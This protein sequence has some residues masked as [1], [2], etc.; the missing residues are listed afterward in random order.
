MRAKIGRNDD[1]S[2]GSG[3]K[4][5]KCCGRAGAGA[6]AAGIREP[7]P[8]TVAEMLE[9]LRSGRHAE[10]ETQVR[11]ALETHPERG[12]L[13]KL[14]A[15]ALHAQHR[16]P[17]EALESAVRLLPKDP[18]A[19][20]N[21]GNALRARG[22]LDEA[23]EQHRRAIRLDASYAEAQVNLGSV[24]HEQGRLGEAAVSFRKATIS[25]P[26]LTLAHHNLGIV[27]LGLGRREEALESFRRALAIEPGH[28]GAL[29]QAADTLLVLERFGEAAEHYHRLIALRPE[30]PEAHSNLGRALRAMG[31]L[32]AA[33]EAQRRALEL[34]PGSAELH[35]NFGSAR[36]ELGRFEEAAASYRRALEL[37]PGLAK[38][39][40]NLG[41]A[42]RE[43]GR[44]AEAEAT[45]EQALALEPDS[46]DT[47]ARLATVQRLQGDA[48]RA[49]A[50]IKRA[51]ELDPG[52]GPATIE[53]ANLALERG[54]FESAEALYREGFVR[55]STSAAAWAGI[56]ATRR[57]TPADAPWFLQAEQLAG[58]Q[59]PLQD[60]M[61]LRFA[62]GKYLDDIGEYDRAFA[63]Y[64]HAN[65][66]ARTSRPPHDRRQLSEW[67]GC[68]RQFY[69]AGWIDSSRSQR[70]TERRPIFVVGMPR[71]GTSLVE[72][73]LASHPTVF[74]AGE[75]SF[76][77]TASL[78]VAA[79]SLESNAGPISPES[80]AAEYDALLAAL[81][82]E[83]RHVVDKMP[84]N[85]AHLGLI[86]TALPAAR[87]IHVR[88]HPIDTCLSI[89]F[90]NFS[91]VAHSYANDLHDI[92][93]YYEEYQRLMS[94][95][96]M[97]LPP[98][99]ILEVPYEALV[100]DPESWGRRMVEFVGL[101]WDERCLDFHRTTRSV[102]TASS[103]Q[104]RQRISAAS[105]QRW[106]HY[107]AHVEPLLK[108]APAGDP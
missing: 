39:H 84:A 25:K 82:G 49:E 19:H 105:V 13:W 75:L 36:F 73:I 63:S 2:C 66:L 90:Q 60:E 5:K 15:A 68:I 29:Q 48:A 98:A 89:Y 44:L 21:L 55:D 7:A 67:F 8:A 58:R 30:T 65:E 14:L 1:C 54:E 87:I 74:G 64:R 85:F 86:H 22:R 3:K 34:R 43:L 102:R 106:R 80:L 96:L 97:V 26:R 32:Q 41:R 61:R 99:S 95:W 31:Q 59:R 108:L 93:H 91:V 47:A 70:P 46:A 81:A 72:Q 6:A 12:V 20:A 38:A 35:N 104:V 11:A 18:E 53:R 33:G 71:S 79:A 100:A 83:Q 51:L 28:S 56:V 37:D 78:R 42:L 17:F 45:L 94:H 4:Y 52:H 40:A 88:R 23:A 62:M 10:L 57:M 103:W 9:L 77:A 27:L 69:D 101:S 16:D 76:W 107:A 50:S 92:A 24:L